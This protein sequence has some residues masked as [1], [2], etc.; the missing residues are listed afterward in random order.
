MGDKGLSHKVGLGLGPLGPRS[1]GSLGDLLKER[2]LLP[3]DFPPVPE[4]G[5]SWT[6]FRA[7][8]LFVWGYA[9]IRCRAGQ[10]SL[11]L[12]KTTPAIDKASSGVTD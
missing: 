5:G 8:P 10:V 7:S 4:G 2:G 9:L 3:G 6:V 12:I 11:G 1:E